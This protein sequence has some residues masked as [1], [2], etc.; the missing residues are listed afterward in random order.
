VGGAGGAAAR[1]VV[2]LTAPREPSANLVGDEELQ[3]FPGWRSF[4]QYLNP[5]LKGLIKI[6][7][8]FLPAYFMVGPWYAMLWL[9]ITGFRTTVADLIST[10]GLDL[11]HWKSDNVDKENVTNAMFWTGFSVPILST[12]KA[13]FDAGWGALGWETGTFLF[14]MAKFWVIALANGLYITTHNRLRGFPK[15][16][17]RANFFRTVLSWPL[18]TLASYGLDPLAVPAIVQ[19]KVWSDVVAGIIE[20][21]GKFAA[22]LKLRE[23]D[24]VELCDQIVK[25]DRATALVAATDVLYVWARRDRGRTALG[26]LMR[27]SIPGSQAFHLMVPHD[28]ET[29]RKAHDRLTEI[30]SAEGSMESLTGMILQNYSGREAVQLCQFVADNHQPFLRWLRQTK[31]R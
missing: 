3:H 18:A 17:I 24:F 21:T 13:G 19:A 30:F 28:R 20:G 22:R 16:V 10:N 15:G 29:V 25:A 7:I 12:A 2:A 11:R 31:P 14:T 5:N 8:G 9:G 23:R 4:W 27:G 26:N 1:R 6:L